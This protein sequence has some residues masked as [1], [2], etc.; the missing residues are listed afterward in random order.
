[1]AIIDDIS[2]LYAAYF[3]RAPDPAGLSFWVGR[4]N[5]VGGPAMS[6]VEIAN[7]FAVQPEATNLYGFL[8]SPLV[9]SP[10]AFLSS[11]Y[12]NLFGRIA[13]AVT[14]AEGFA[15]WTAQLANPAIGVGRVILDIRSGAQGNDLQVIN[16][17]TAVG[18]AFVQKLVETGGVFSPALAQSAFVGVSADAASVASTISRNNLMISDVTAPVVTAAQTFHYI[19]NRAAGETLGTVLAT[20]NAGGSGVGGFS[21]VSGNSDGFFAI[22]SKGAITLTQAGA[23]ATV[24]ANDFELAPNSFTLGVSAIDFS[25]NRGAA[26][27]VTLNVANADDTAPTLRDASARNLSILLNFDEV[28]TPGGVRTSAFTVQDA[29]NATIAVSAVNISGSQVTL[30]LAAPPAIAARVVYTPPDSGDALQDSSGNRVA[31]TNV[32]VNVSAPSVLSN[33]LTLSFNDPGGTLAP[34]EAAISQ[35]VNAAWNLWAVHFTRTAPIEL[36]I[37]VM[38]GAPTTLASARSLVTQNS[39]EFFQ[40]KR[41]LQVGVAFELATGSDPNGAAPDAEISLGTD[42]SRFVFRSSL[43]EPVPRDKFDAISVFAHEIGHILGF[44]SSTSLS[45]GFVGSFERYITGTTSP[46]FSGP[47]AIAANAGIPILLDPNSPSHLADATDLMSARIVN[48]QER[49]VEPV[50]IA[51]LQDVGVPISLLNTGGL[52]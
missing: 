40:G 3:N 7:S 13:T 47:N 41:V 30:T 16:N 42:L 19:E 38:P 27:L 11:V 28:L 43:N 36:E 26:A 18:V 15:Y 4:A 50:H 44:N 25:G 33:N 17:K 22:D 35:S 1:L 45:G 24:A 6:L 5:G 12:L 20:D 2:A 39:G 9:A 10:T 23:R 31:A 46:A 21:I 8:S 29:N 52:V 48:G 49:L 34:F 37:N 51:I 14:D 32:T